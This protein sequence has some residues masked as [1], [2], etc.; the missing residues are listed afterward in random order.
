MNSVAWEAARSV[1]S[2]VL[3][4]GGLAVIGA[5]GKPVEAPQTG[6]YRAS[7]EL[8]GGEAPFRLEVARENGRFALYLVNATERTR[9]DNVTLADGELSAVFPGYENTLRATMYRDRLEGNVTLIKDASKEQVI[10][11]RAKRN[12][13]Y[14]FYKDA[15]TDNADFAGRWEMTLTSDGKSSPAVAIFEQQHDRITGTVM[16]PT[17]DHRFLEGQAHGDEAQLSTFAGGLAYLYKLKVD[18]NGELEGDMWQGLASHSKVRAHR[19]DDA[20]LDGK[21]PST[22]LQDQSSRFDFTF[23]DLNGNEVSLHDPK[24]RDK[25]VVVTLGGSWCPNCHDEAE[26]LVPFYREYQPKG[27]EIIALMFERHGEFERAASA[28]GNY[29]KDLG[30]EFTT[31]IAGVSDTDEA[32]K[33]L[34]ALT[35]IYGYPTTIVVDRAGTVRD[36]HVGF[37]GPATGKHY[38]EYV[39]EFRALI[40]ELLA[41]PAASA[42]SG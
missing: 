2:R 27:V 36:I 10:P 24:F 16:T 13:T 20:T 35:G 28:V 42:V 25:V 31:L 4:A 5:C 19:N 12:Q 32:S 30:I 26:F 17:G 9:V 11:F 37:S 38:E 34:P 15:V 29:R 22:E 18:A 40:D 21:G 6:V 1:C 39:S 7:L 33:A 14:R 3:L 41:E 23:K 8:P